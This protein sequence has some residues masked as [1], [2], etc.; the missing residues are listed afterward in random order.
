MSGFLT[1]LKLQAI[2]NCKSE[3]EEKMGNQISKV[4]PNYEL[5][6]G[7]YV[8]WIKIFTDEDAD[9]VL[10]KLKEILGGNII[11]FGSLLFEKGYE[12]LVELEKV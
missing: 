4:F 9:Y 12:F 6:F 5:D 8:I 1:H 2:D 10:K 3:F 11:P 7:F